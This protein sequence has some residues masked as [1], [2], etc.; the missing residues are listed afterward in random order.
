MLT[1]ADVLDL[2]VVKQ[3]LPEIVAGQEHLDGPVRWAHVVDVA[4]VAGLLKGREFVFNH[5][6]GI[7]TDAMVQRDFVRELAAQEAAALAV[8]LG[9]C[10][11][12]SLPAPMAREAERVGLPLIA[13]H[14]KTRFVEVTEAIHQRLM[15]NDLVVLRAADEFTARL[16]QAI[17]GGADIP[18]IL[19]EVA[20][21]VRNPVVL[22][23]ISQRLVGVATHQSSEQIAVRAWRDLVEAEDRDHEASPRGTV[24]APVRL[25]DRQW[26][27]VVALEIDHPFDD[28]TEVF[29]ERAA[30]AVSLRLVSHE[31]ANSLTT[32]LRGE[33]L[34]ELIAGRLTE[35]E[36]ARRAQ[37]VGFERRSRT[38]LPLALAWRGGKRKEAESDPI[39]WALLAGELRDALARARLPTLIGTRASDLLLVV[40]PVVA[41]EVTSAIARVAATLLDGA[42]RQQLS[43]EDFAISVGPPADNWV[44]LGRGLDRA[45]RHAPVAAREDPAPWHDARRVRLNDVLSELAESPTLRAFVTD[46]LGA[47]MDTGADRRNG[48][49]LHTLEVYL[50]HG[51]RKTAAA[52]ALHLERQSLYQ[53]LRRLES[54]LGVDWQDSGDLLELQLALRLRRVLSADV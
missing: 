50:D 29:V 48:Q 36:A 8:E 51:G 46:Q 17:L 26:G 7:G 27:R 19:N 34:G 33:L 14:R 52:H 38:L 30:A 25:L 13:L 12:G 15:A 31:H 28:V 1:V 20:T 53:R 35:P 18:E 39:G 40:D 54:I 5:G 44:D 9:I 32:R 21:A 3:G 16:T 11:R 47:L 43:E 41:G 10:F 24:E 45:L 37:A 4:E 6:L 23:G 49:L 2:P 42:R 22:D